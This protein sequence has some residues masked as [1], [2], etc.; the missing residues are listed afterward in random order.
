MQMGADH[1]LDL[2]SDT[3]HLIVGSADTLKYQYVARERD[4]IKVLG[5]EWIEAVRDQWITDLPLD[6]D[7]ITEQ[8]RVPTLAGLKI[9]ITGF[10]DLSFRAQLQKNVKDNGGEYTGDLTKD[11]THLIAARPEGKKYE[12]GMQWQKKVVSLKWYKDTLER[13]MQLDESLYHP[14]IPTVEQG[15]GAWNRKPRTSPQLG[16]RTRE[17]K[18]GPEP[19]RKLRRT[20]SARLGSQNQDM[21]SDIVGGAG[22]EAR[23]DERPQ[24][25]PSVSM[26]ALPRVDTNS[27]GAQTPQADQV[28]GRSGLDPIHTTNGVFTGR[29]FM[30][31]FFDEKRVSSWSCLSSLATICAYAGLEASPET[32]LSRPRCSSRK[33]R[34]SSNC[35][36]ACQYIPHLATRRGQEWFEA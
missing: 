20:A 3:T 11:V 17:D 36:R 21:W 29:R 16:K 31:R 8:H 26:P 23:A 33:R 6:L 5:P 27:I 32:H 1:K 2:T 13:R 30:L 28:I 18:V 4:D 19:S 22:F 12:Y 10:D 35:R 7:A 15:V 14:T 34:G 25:K 9:C 24:L